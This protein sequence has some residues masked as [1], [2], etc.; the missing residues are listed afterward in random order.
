MASVVSEDS[1]D[2]LSDNSQFSLPWNETSS[3]FSEQNS[4]RESPINS[5]N[6]NIVH[7]LCNR[8]IYGRFTRHPRAKTERAFNS[9]HPKCRLPIN[10]LASNNQSLLDNVFMG[11]TICGKYFLTYSVKILTDLNGLNYGSVFCYE[12]EL[13]VWAF[14]PGQRLKLC[15]RHKIFKHL[16][17]TDSLDTIYFMQ[18]PSDIYKVI[19]YGVSGPAPDIVHISIMTL[20]TSNCKHCKGALS[21]MGDSLSQ[22]WCEKHGFMIHYMVS[23][24][25]PSHAFDPQ[26]SLA[27]PDHLVIN[28]GPNIH[29]L[30]VETV[31]PVHNN[32]LD[33]EEVIKMISANCNDN[34]SEVS[35]STSEHFGTSSIVDAILEDFS[36]YDMD[37]SECNKP[38]HELNISC[39]PLN[40]T[41]KS[42]HNTLVQNIVDPRLK[43][44]QSGK[45]YPFSIPHSSNNQ[46]PLEKT[47]IDKKTAEKAYEF[48]EENEKC[49]KLSS[50][51]K[52]RLAEKKYEFSEDNSE[53]IVPFNSLRRDRN[54]RSP[55][56]RS[57]MQS[58][59][60][61]TAG[62]FS[63]SGARNLY[64][65]SATRNSPHHS[66]SPISPRGDSAR[67]FYVYSPSLD[68]E[69][70]DPDSRLIMRTS[71]SSSG[72]G[73]DSRGF[74]G[75]LI[76]DPAKS[77]TPKWIRKVVR[78]YSNGDFE[79][80]SLLSGQ[81]RDDNNLS[82]EIPLLVQNLTEQHLDMV[83]E[84]R[85]DQVS[86]MQLI[87]TQ[88][89]FDCEQF[90]YRQAEKLCQETNYEFL[91]CDDYDIK[92][93]HIC[94]INGYIV[95]Q[96]AIKV[97]ALKT[98]EPN[99]RPQYFSS[100]LL[101]TW[102]IATDAFVVV[103][104]SKLMPSDCFRKTLH[105]DIPRPNSKE[106]LVMD[107]NFTATKTKLRD[108]N[109]LYEVN[110]VPPDQPF[111][112]MRRPRTFEI[113][114]YEYSSDD[115]D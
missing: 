107:L 113:D 35:E 55:G 98:S 86:E 80:S 29:I 79:N 46:K 63:P 9:I 60:S 97:G 6:T 38:F 17:G 4:N 90:I 30:N 28:T 25:Q 22:G 100:H 69:C 8:Q 39:E 37:S 104:G 93:I 76:V 87:V 64:C 42:Y 44:L 115:S 75:L 32:S 62:Q 45:D 58:P 36:E 92:I 31:K 89:T 23:N 53:N 73:T 106:V 52:K 26:I 51:R 50:F 70:S 114:E 7:N 14:V 109:N 16:K 83:P 19:C 68:S 41:G 74:G 5:R 67:K 112:L 56:L 108:Y 34:L 91:H 2:Y 59:N 71:T 18:F 102:S 77:E 85:V 49:E 3:N 13:L 33:K 99:G 65:P 78:R 72:G 110:I 48:I 105:I 57:P 101:F 27:Y 81:S 95:C 88:R 103:E 94:P 40:V 61:R 20:P 96:A 15:S 84:Y 1:D 12:Y 24:T 21:E 11:F 47:K 111:I 82:I 66:K 43:R 10:T 54:P